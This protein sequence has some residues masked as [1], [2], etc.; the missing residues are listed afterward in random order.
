MN[1]NEVSE[2]QGEYPYPPIKH[3]VNDKDVSIIGVAH[4]D[5]FFEEHEDFFRKVIDDHDALILEAYGS[6]AID[7]FFWQLAYIAGEKGKNVYNVDPDNRFVRFGEL[8]LV[9]LA[10][11]Y[12]FHL[13]YDFNERIKNGS[14]KMSRRNFLKRTLIG[15]LAGSK[16]LGS[17]GATCRG[18]INEDLLLEHGWDDI[19]MYGEL[20][21]R[22]VKIAEGIRKVCDEATDISSIAAIHGMGH[23]KGIE[24]Y[25]MNPDLMKK[26]YAY[27]PY[28]LLGSGIRKYE[29]DHVFTTYF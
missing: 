12:F 27:L 14:K 24:A 3:R 21:Y 13:A 19:L 22:N 7:D 25:L 5:P 8:I 1:N 17:L 20:D 18:L 2:G 28:D 29:P 11:A 16:I 4:T 23:S 9:G 15:C 10:T 26:K 6:G